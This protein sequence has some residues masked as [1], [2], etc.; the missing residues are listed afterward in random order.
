MV[1][2]CT[3]AA[4]WTLLLGTL[5]A[6]TSQQELRKGELATLMAA[7]PGVYDNLNQVQADAAAG[8]DGAHAPQALLILRLQSPLIGDDVL[9]VR[10]TAADDPRRVTAER[11]WS[12]KIDAAGRI[13][14]TQ[15]RFE[16]PD[17][18]RIGLESPEL[19][20]SLLLRDLQVVE[21]CELQWQKT[22]SGFSGDVAGSACH[23]GA[24]GG[25]LQ[26]QHWRLGSEA[27]ELSEAAAA[28]A[29]PG[30]AGTMGADSYR[31]QRRSASQ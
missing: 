25:A 20:R 29:A 18:W 9:Y 1:E 19:F 21:G 15:A 31:F 16:E 12:L 2:R 22:A 17:R 26:L 30:A 7:L 5:A 10:E 14:G 3:G 11:V 13:L 28:P 6:C 8:H 4:L 23:R 27:L 24:S